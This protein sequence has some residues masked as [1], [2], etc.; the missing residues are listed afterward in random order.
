MGLNP[1]QERIVKTLEGPLF[2]SAGAGSG[3]TFV[4]T[5]RIMHALRPGS[6]PQ[7]Q[8]ADPSIPEPFLDSIDQVLAITFTEK[9]AEELKERI[10]AAL[11]KEGMEA[12]AAKV[13]SA[14]ISTIH[15]M[16]SRIIRAHALDLGLDPTFGVAEYAEDL[17]RSAVEHVLRRAVLED[18]HGA[19]AYDELLAAFDL[20]GSGMSHSATSLMAIL[21]KILSAVSS[22]VYGLD[23]FEQ[24]KARPS[25]RLLMEVYRVIAE[26]PSYANAEAAQVALAALDAYASSA[27]DLPALRACFSACDKLNKRARGM[28]KDEKAAVDALRIERTAFFAEAYLA[29]RG[30]ALDQL[31]SLAAEVQ[32]EFD[33]LKSQKSLLDNDDLLTRAYDA[34]KNDPIVRAEFA[35][36]FKMVMVDEFQDTAQQQVELVSLLCSPSGRELCTVGDAQQSIYRFRGA[37]VSVFRNKKREVTHSGAVYSLET[38][39]RSHA[40][41]LSFADK[42]FEGGDTNP[43]GRDFL[44]LESCGEEQRSG[45]RVLACEA[46]TRRQAVLVAGGDGATRATCKAQAVATRLARLREEEGFAPSDMVILMKQLTHADVYAQ[47]VR[48]AGMPCVVSGGTSV[49][50]KA[51]EINAITAL[52]MFLANPDDGQQGLMPLLS[53]PMFG[54]GA[55]ELLALATHV[56]EQSRIVDSRTLTGSVFLSG[57]LL[58]VFGDLPL[59]A[60][61]REV[62]GRALSRVG[63]DSMAVIVRDAVHESGWLYR[64]EQQGRAQDRAVA[65]N[66][67]KALDIVEQ[68]SAGREFAPRL[69]ARAFANHIQHIKESPATLNGADEDAVRIM[70]V[71]AS[72][73]LEFPVVVVAECDGISGDGDLLQLRECDGSIRWAAMPS[74]HALASDKDML[75]VPV[76]DED[77]GE[78]GRPRE[79]PAT[80]AGAYAFMKRENRQL[81]YE[82]A[83]RLLY[84]ALTRAREVAILAM[85]A[86]SASELVPGHA[87]SLLGEV[88]SRILPVDEGND[89]LP[90]LAAGHL[91]FS[92]SHTGD[93]Q[94]VVLDEEFHYPA[95]KGVHRTYAGAEFGLDARHEADNADLPIVERMAAVLADVAEKQAAGIDAVA[96]EQEADERAAQ[97][98]AAAPRRFT[99]VKPASVETCVIPSVHSPRSSYSYSSISRELH[100]V[101]EDR[102]AGTAARAVFDEGTDGEVVAGRHGFEQAL[103]AAEASGIVRGR[104]DGASDAT[105]LGSVFH[106]ACQWMIEMGADAV[107]ADRLDAL[108]RFW[109]CSAVQRGRIE[110]ALERWYGSEVRAEALA[111]PVVRAEVPFFSR[112]MDGLT[113]QFAPF[114]EG[115]IDLLCTDPCHP[116]CALVIDYK[117]G[118]SAAETPEQ[119]QEKHHLQAQVYADVLHKQGYANVTLKFVRVEQPD[120]LSPSQPQVVTYEL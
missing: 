46:T 94:L 115:A 27:K 35:G 102:D 120:P 67:L 9:A 111:W 17:K 19:G 62:L 95:K 91:D 32:R 97:K 42:I 48:A 75:E 2:V 18:A 88:L 26:T 86:R 72:K 37:D 3:K 12:E 57:E 52:L 113:E 45:A 34:L 25:H 24:V 61:A 39:Y 70:T 76:L 110:V 20:E 44:H 90:D 108:C 71:H 116:E 5:Q 14:W 10:R 82:E 69:V 40:D 117:T 64:L 83:A 99:L 74:R 41:I 36:R 118:G 92:D 105:A 80:A 112:G 96:E 114:A 109:G 51:P 31:M 30:P 68:E 81:D 59:L 50:R 8:W 85:G 103:A 47:A 56:D 84:V 23:A 29:Q 100:A 89:G 49:F 21:T 55:T 4:L 33:E 66:V 28:G 6:K 77:D 98:D 104:D 93:F 60:R 87:T 106:D 43:L 65:A 15:G 101:A 107:P 38:N 7:D 16:C 79:M 1:Q 78:D 11:L 54:L 53:S 13:D 58:E 73:G 22:S 63:R 119:L